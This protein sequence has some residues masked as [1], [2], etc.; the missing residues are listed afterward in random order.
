MNGGRRQFQ[1]P[2][3]FGNGL[4]PSAEVS[5]RTITAEEEVDLVLSGED[6]SC[7]KHLHLS[8]SVIIIINMVESSEFIASPNAKK[9][10]LDAGKASAIAVLNSGKR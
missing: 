10:L 1:F 6:L 2:R 3:G 4:D 7:M 9:R 8:A 5:H